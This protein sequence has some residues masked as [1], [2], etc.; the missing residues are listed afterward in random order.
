VE[1]F[2]M[3]PSGSALWS[4]EDAKRLRDL[5]EAV[6]LERTCAARLACL[7]VAQWSQLEDGGRSHFYTPQIM[8]L[9]GLRATTAL[10]RRAA[11]QTP[12]ADQSIKA[13]PS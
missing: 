2:E 3:K 8:A 10:Q 13:P 9:A 1:R 12:A 5:R 7:S 4:D 6:G 11:Q